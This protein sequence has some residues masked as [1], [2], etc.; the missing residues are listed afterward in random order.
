[1]V[2]LNV[3]FVLWNKMWWQCPSSCLV[4]S[5]GK[6][7]AVLC[8]YCLKC[9]CY[10]Q[11]KKSHLCFVQLLWIKL[12]YVNHTAHKLTCVRATVILQI[13]MRLYLL[14]LQKV[15]SFELKYC[16]IFISPGLI[17]SLKCKKYFYGMQNVI[18]YLYLFICYPSHLTWLP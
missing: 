2:D 16:K 11:K 18:S 9:I 6:F 1:M 13:W 3:S 10:C 7:A 12:P 14:S 17:S 15:H 5:K 4:G 8:I